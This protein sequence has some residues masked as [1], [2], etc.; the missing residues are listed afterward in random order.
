MRAAGWPAASQ[1]GVNLL[2]AAMCPLGAALF[3]LGMSQVAYDAGR[4]TGIVLAFS[5]GVFVC[6]ALSDLLPEM[7]FHSHDRGRLTVALLLGLGLAW[8]LAWVSPTHRRPLTSPDSRTDSAAVHGPI[9]EIL[10][11]RAQ[12]RI[13]ICSLVGDDFYSQRTR[14]AWANRG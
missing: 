14:R 8:G 13:D 9:H 7:E 11:P 1:L 6:I 10:A 3:V 5:A 2:F 12:D 4:V